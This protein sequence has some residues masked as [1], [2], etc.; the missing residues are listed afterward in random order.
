MTARARGSIRFP[1]RVW[2]LLGIVLLGLYEGAEGQGGTAS[3]GGESRVRASVDSGGVVQ[4][5]PEGAPFLLL[6]VGGRA[7]GLGRA[8]TA[9]SGSEAPF[10]NPAGLTG[11]NDARVIVA[12][13]EHI[14]GEALTLSLQGV[15]WS[16]LRGAF[17]LQVLD[18]GSQD[19][20]DLD[21]NVV[22][23]LTNRS[24]LG[25][26]TV[27]R[28]WG[29]W[30]HLGANLKY[31]QFTLGCRGQC[32]QGRVRASS[33]GV[34]VG[35]RLRPLPDRPWHVGV[36][37]VHLGPDFRNRDAAE[38]D[39]L[40]RRIRVGIAGIPW[41]TT[42]EGERLAIL[43]SVDAEARSLDQGERAV[44]L[45]AEFSAG[46]TDQ[47]F[48]RGGYS[49]GQSPGLDGASVGFGFRF[50]RFEL[51]LARGLPRGGIASRQEPTHLTLAVR[52]P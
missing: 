43:L 46:S 4:P 24:H 21:G 25:M 6:P 30:L 32:P 31:F 27:A 40:P 2:S 23:A 19:A 29:D 35:G 3:T 20:T 36:A 17:T 42:V 18:E 38:G 22:G 5:R 50:D 16:D 34:D 51:D 37:L 14:T 12:R 10:W 52:L 9:V 8:M 33:Y 49:T 47:L 45:G 39:P 1:L 28:G 15:G 11:I 13:G 44:L 7:V 48:V 26:V 41:E